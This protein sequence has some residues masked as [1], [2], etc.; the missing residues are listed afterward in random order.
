MKPLMPRVVLRRL[1]RMEDVTLRCVSDAAAATTR[2][3]RAAALS[4]I[5]CHCALALADIERLVRR[6]AASDADAAPPPFCASSFRDEAADTL[7]STSAE[8]L[9]RAAQRLRD[10][11]DDEAADVVDRYGRVRGALAASL[12]HATR[13]PR[14]AA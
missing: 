12:Q 8:L 14:T 2:F 10:A 13:A 11:G 4:D 1:W 6:D 3:A 7:T 9:L 5:A